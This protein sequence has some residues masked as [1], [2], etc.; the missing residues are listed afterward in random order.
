MTGNPYLKIKTKEHP[1]PERKLKTL[2][3]LHFNKDIS[4]TI[5]K[6][7]D[8]NMDD[9]SVI[10]YVDPCTHGGKIFFER[11]LNEEGEKEVLLDELYP[12]Q[13]TGHLKKYHNDWAYNS[14]FLPVSG[15]MKQTVSNQIDK[16]LD[17]GQ[18]RFYFAY[19]YNT[20]KWHTGYN[21]KYEVYKQQKEK[22]NK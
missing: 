12:K 19:D 3:K 5:K 6:V 10:M 8:E 4:S 7:L 9:D 11:V 2:L 15:C 20:R 17:D 16:Y 18:G 14:I 22:G 21:L 1:L 13:R